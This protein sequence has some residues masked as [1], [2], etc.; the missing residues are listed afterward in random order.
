VIDS[1]KSLANASEAMCRNWQSDSNEIDGKDLQ[2][3]KQPLSRLSI[4]RGIVID[5]DEEFLNASSPL[6]FKA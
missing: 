4:C 2:W 5:L 3:K 6:H 1:S